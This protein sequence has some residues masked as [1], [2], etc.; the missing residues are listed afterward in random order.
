[1]PKTIVDIIEDVKQQEL[2]Y[3]I[4]EYSVYNNEKN[5][6]NPIPAV[7]YTHLCLYLPKDRTQPPFL[8]SSVGISHSEDG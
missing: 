2:E 5:Y 6:Y 8:K 4:K 7:S 3:G 1:M